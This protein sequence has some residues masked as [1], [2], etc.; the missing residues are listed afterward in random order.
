MEYINQYGH[1]AIVEGDIAQYDNGPKKRKGIGV[2]YANGGLLGGYLSSFN[3]LF[4]DETIV[5]EN[6]LG[7]IIETKLGN[8][9]DAYNLLREKMNGVDNTNILEISNAVLETV[10]EYF[11]GIKNSQYREKYY[12][13]NDFEERKNNRISNLKGS[14]A[15]V[16]V[17]RAALSQNLLKSLGINSV[18]KASEIFKNNNREYHSY[19]LV[20]FDQKYYIFDSAMPNVVNNTV[21]PLICEI[22]KETFDLI[23]APV[24]FIGSSVTVNHF[25]P[26]RN[27]DVNI[28]YDSGRNR[29]IS[30]DPITDMNY[31]L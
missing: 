7:D 27:V 4:R 31:N 13:S 26:Y 29:Q 8:V 3:G 9:D 23:S 18:Y 21:S 12:F 25:N 16:C 5:I 20:E 6:G 19:N 11:G 28:T 15:A 17:E 14:G 24:Y 2:N 22:D 1:K 30:V 10:D